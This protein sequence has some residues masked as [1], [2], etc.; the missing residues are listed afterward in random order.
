MNAFFKKITLMLLVICS[1]SACK[2]EEKSFEDKYVAGFKTYDD[3]LASGE[4][5]NIKVSE[6]KDRL[7]MTYGR[8]S[9]NLSFI[10]GIFT[11]SNVEPVSVVMSTDLSG[12]L[13]WRNTIPAGLFTSSLVELSDG[14]CL[15]VGADRRG[16]N[17]AID[18]KKIYVFRYDRKGELIS[19]DSLL[20]GDEFGGYVFYN[21]GV[22]SLSGNDVMIYGSILDGNTYSARG[23]SIKYNPLSGTEFIKPVDFG[24]SS[25]PNNMTSIYNCIKTIDNG[26]MFLGTFFSSI[27]PGNPFSNKTVLIKTDN[28]CDTTWT[29]WF[30]NL[31]VDPLQEILQPTN[32]IQAKSGDYYLCFNDIPDFENIYSF[33]GFIYKVSALGDSIAGYSIKGPGNSYCSLIIED[34]NFGVVGL[35]NEFPGYL[36]Y[37]FKPTYTQFQTQLVG[38]NSNLKKISTTLIQDSRTDFYSTACK[39]KD[40]RIAFFGLHRTNNFNSFVPALII[41]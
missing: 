5:P 37:E 22:L 35:F 13:I 7:F 4:N 24:T 8:G 40:G 12:N 17:P 38:F 15:I 6:G 28:N 1:L 25:T 10:N 14:S 2:K 30:D 36:Y 16:F 23:F 9:F 34:D 31:N 29:K 33:K 19:N 3:T 18:D 32:V 39:L 21:L 26:F 27:Q 20:L 41:K 11:F